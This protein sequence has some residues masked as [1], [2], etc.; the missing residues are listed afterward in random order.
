[1]Q[2]NEEKQSNM[3]SNKIKAGTKVVMTHSQRQ[4]FLKKS[5]LGKRF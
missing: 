5:F 1:M 2:V 3:N 4:A